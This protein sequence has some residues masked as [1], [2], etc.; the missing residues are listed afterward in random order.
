MPLNKFYGDRLAAVSAGSKQ[1]VALPA[2]RAAQ[3]PI[4]LNRWFRNGKSPNAVTCSG[5]NEAA[6]QAVLFRSKCVFQWGSYVYNDT[7]NGLLTSQVGSERERWK[8]AFHTSPYAHS[9]Y[10]VCLEFQDT[11]APFFLLN[12]G[13]RLDLRTS[14]LSTGSVVST[15]NFHY[16]AHP[17]GNS[18]G[19]F[20]DWSHV[21][22]IEGYL[23]VTPDTDYYGVLT[24]YDGGRLFAVVAF[25]LASLTEN[26]GGYLAQNISVQSPILDVYREKAAQIIKNMWTRGAAAVLHWTVND[27]TNNYRLSAAGNIKNVVDDINPAVYNANA[28]GWTLDMQK[29]VRLSEAAAGVPCVMKAY[30]RSGIAN[31]GGTVHLRDSAGTIVAQIVNGWNATASWQSVTFNLPATNAKYYLTYTAAD[32]SFRLHAISI[33]QHQ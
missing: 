1:V 4:Q 17:S 32:T 10:V 27:S 29:R 20:D 14:N 7:I 15:R 9:I 18:S 16:G 30:G 12:P 19:F 26:A 2:T 11:A 24:D 13:V 31:P 25:E 6:N 33:Y 3:P 23:D 21:K 22:A 8:F 5:L 28:F